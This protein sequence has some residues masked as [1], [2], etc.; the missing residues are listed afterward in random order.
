M[1]SNLASI[2]GN[3]DLTEQQMF[4][5]ILHSIGLVSP[6]N[7]MT[8][9]SEDFEAGNDYTNTEP[10]VVEAGDHAAI[11][12]KN[13]YDPL[14]LSALSEY[15]KRLATDILCDAKDYSSHA[16]HA[17]IEVSDAKL[18]LKLYDSRIAGVDTRLKHLHDMKNELNSKPLPPIPSS[19]RERLFPAEYNLL[20]R[21][22]TL[23]SGAEAYPKVSQ[24]FTTISFSSFHFIFMKNLTDK[25]TG[26]QNGSISSSGS[27]NAFN[28][29][30]KAKIDV[31]KHGVTVQNDRIQ[32]NPSIQYSALGYYPSFA[33]HI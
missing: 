8:E 7:I 25:L 3:K 11:N 32:F 31:R 29:Q 13:T 27:N 10:M 9:T 15:A 2:S 1:M 22:Y 26:Q 16:G 6:K 12:E 17:D 18:A 33:L 14:V 30:E 5:Q 28:L 23:I 21:T 19:C 24:I 4:E 20:N